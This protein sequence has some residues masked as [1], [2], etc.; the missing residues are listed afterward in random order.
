MA[1][2]CGAAVSRR[3]T[4]A[5]KKA[6]DSEQRLIDCFVPEAQLVLLAWTELAAGTPHQ[7]LQCTAR[8][9]AE[10]EASCSMLKPLRLAKPRGVCAAVCGGWR[11]PAARP[12]RLG[13]RSSSA[14]CGLARSTT[15]ACRSPDRDLAAPAQNLMLWLGLVWRTPPIGWRICSMSCAMNRRVASQPPWLNLPIRRTPVARPLTRASNS[16]LGA[17]LLDVT[18]SPQ[19]KV[20]D[21][22]S[23]RVLAWCGRSVWRPAQGGRAGR[24]AYGPVGR[25]LYRSD[26]PGSCCL[27]PTRGAA[28]GRAFA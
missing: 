4:W 28:S 14:L 2:R 5:V 23:Q 13:A 12:G 3:V 16:S 1:Q 15:I 7:P 11:P 20:G 27:F 22:L 9:V 17:R 18:K 24:A 21:R 10:S 25:Q 19:K 6:I 26:G 8:S